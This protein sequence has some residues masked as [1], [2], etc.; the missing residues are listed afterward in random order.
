MMFRIPTINF[1]LMR[2]RKQKAFQRA[3]KTKYT[4]L[5]FGLTLFL[6][7]KVRSKSATVNNNVH[8][9]IANRD[10]MVGNLRVFRCILS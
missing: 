3:G 9:I 6:K 1:M 2:R 4:C 7:H 8:K 10:G 5:F